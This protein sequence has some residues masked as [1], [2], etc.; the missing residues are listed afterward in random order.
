MDAEQRKVAKAAFSSLYRKAKAAVNP[1]SA[2]GAQAAAKGSRQKAATEA[3]RQ[4]RPE[5]I[6]VQ[7]ESGGASKAIG[8]QPA[9]PTPA[10]KPVSVSD[11]NT[12]WYSQM[13]QVRGIAR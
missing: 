6:V 11:Y 10:A 12:Q 7:R 2:G 3:S 1:G 4:E 13:M 9:Q 5:T 8:T